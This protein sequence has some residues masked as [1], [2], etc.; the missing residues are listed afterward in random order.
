MPPKAQTGVATAPETVEQ[1]PRLTHSEQRPLAGCA[2]RLM[3][4]SLFSLTSYFS[5]IDAH[6]QGHP[7]LYASLPSLPAQHTSLHHQKPS[8]LE[9][10]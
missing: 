7:R 5:S 8:F 10:F 2:V 4:S 1:A 3:K 9:A 6:N